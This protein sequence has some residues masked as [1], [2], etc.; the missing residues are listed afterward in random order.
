MDSIADYCLLDRLPVEY[1]SM[2]NA[3]LKL[4]RSTIDDKD[5]LKNLYLYYAHDLSE[6]NDSLKTDPNGLF[7]NSIDLY[8]NDDRLIPLKII[9]DNSIIGFLFCST[10]Q[11]VDYIVQEMFILR[12]YRNRGL[13]KLALK[14]LFNLYPGRYGLVIL[15][16]NEPAKL[17]W[18]HCLEHLGIN[19]TSS[20]VIEDG[21]LCTRL[22]FDS[23]KS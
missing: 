1:G 6:F 14:Q 10:G 2:K 21:Q 17:F 23:R 22:I 13:G 4:E 18:T 20:E 11:K 7:G 5:V 9:L 8:F 19:Y 12:N 16:K 15:M 3:D